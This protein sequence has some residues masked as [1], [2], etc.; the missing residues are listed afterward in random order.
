[1]AM[2]RQLKS[3]ASEQAGL[4]EGVLLLISPEQRNLL[5][6]EILYQHNVPVFVIEPG[7][8]NLSEVRKN[9]EVA[10]G[11]FAQ[12]G[13]FEPFHRAQPGCVSTQRS[14]EATTVNVCLSPPFLVALRFGVS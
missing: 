12:A 14:N 1:M 10:N 8:E 3:R 11:E 2:N 5:S 9:G 7:V 4:F 13:A 6:A